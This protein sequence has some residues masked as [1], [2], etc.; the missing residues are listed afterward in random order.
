MVI[1]FT[2]TFYVFVGVVVSHQAAVPN[3]GLQDRPQ[4]LSTE[5]LGGDDDLM[6]KKVKNQRFSLLRPHLVF[7][8][9]VRKSHLFFMLL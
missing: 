5:V 4:T 8:Y 9:R 2:T 1:V 7:V 3:L 6:V